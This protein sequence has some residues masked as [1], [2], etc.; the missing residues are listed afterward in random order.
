MEY[1]YWLLAQIDENFVA[2]CKQQLLLYITKVQIVKASFLDSNVSSIIKT[3][4]VILKL[5][6]FDKIHRVLRMKP[7]PQH[8]N[9]DHH[10]QTDHHEL[11]NGYKS[12]TTGYS[13]HPHTEQQCSSKVGIGCLLQL[14]VGRYIS[15]VERSRQAI[16]RSSIT[17]KNVSLLYQSGIN[18]PAKSFCLTTV[19]VLYFEYHSCVYR[20]Q[21]CTLSL[22][23]PFGCLQRGP[24]MRS[25]RWS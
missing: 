15:N 10:I 12:S 8:E 2:S 21:H 22:N 11:S 1:L 9:D 16:R 5:L 7:P 13:R 25:C 18:M 20:S 14:M 3:L 4:S 17:T 24:R 23:E 6:P 19:Q